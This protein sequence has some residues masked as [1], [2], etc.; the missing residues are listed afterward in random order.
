M[1]K[2]F[3]KKFSRRCSK[4]SRSIAP[5]ATGG[6]TTGRY[7]NISIKFLKIKSYRLKTNATG[8]DIITA[9]KADINAVRNES[10]TAKNIS[11]LNK[12]LEGIEV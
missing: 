4:K 2:I 11:F 8:I 12:V 1:K 6:N 3:F 9:I 10:F 5:I 7:N